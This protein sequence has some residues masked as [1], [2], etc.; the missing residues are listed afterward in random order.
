MP[1]EQPIVTPELLALA[2][3]I[4]E[5]EAKGADVPKAVIEVH[6]GGQVIEVKK[7]KAVGTIDPEQA[8]NREPE[9]TF[10]APAIHPKPKRELKD[11]SIALAIRGQAFGDWRGAEL[12]REWVRSHPAYLRGELTEGVTRTLHAGDDSLGGF[13][14]PEE[15]ASE[16]IPLLKASSVVRAAG[17]TVIPDCP[18]SF[19]LPAQSGAT[20]AYWVGTAALPNA[21]TASEPTFKMIRLELKRV[22]ALAKIDMLLVQKSAAGVEALV[23]R[24]I[25][26]QLAL[27]EDAAYLAGTGG[28]EPLGLINLPGINATG[29]V[30]VPNFDDLFSAMTE[31]EARNGRM[32]AWIMHPSVWNVLR[33]QKTGTAEYLAQP[34]VTDGPRT[35]ALGLPV[36]RTTQ[37]GTGYILAGNWPDYVIGEGGG[38]EIYVLREAYMSQL[39]IGILAVHL[40]DGAPRQVANFQV[41][42]GVTLS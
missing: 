2:K 19:N 20:T 31:I 37:L 25:A 29:S 35:L 21:I 23:R 38:I 24:D 34:N 26:E 12:E 4:L 10:A 16:I 11:F 27:A 32:N 15:T 1:N 18:M 3:Q 40:V 7:P 6:D 9:A 39:Q 17:A 28:A 42:S 5:A 36:Y 41:L 30:G 14:I 8:I 13:L 22:A 33:T